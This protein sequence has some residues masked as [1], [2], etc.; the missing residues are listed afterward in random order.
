MSNKKT[1][2]EMFQDFISWYIGWLYLWSLRMS[3]KEYVQSVI[4]ENIEQSFAADGSPA[5]YIFCECPSCHATGRPGL[6]I[7]RR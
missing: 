1:L 4:L 7:R 3:V 6:F 2:L 5:E